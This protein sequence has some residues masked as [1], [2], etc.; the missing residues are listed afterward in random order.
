MNLPSP[1]TAAQAADMLGA[2]LLGDGTI[3]LTGIN[4]IHHVRSGDMS[5]VDHPKYYKPALESSATVILINKEMEAPEGK[6]LLLTD[7][8][9]R[10][11]NRMMAFA[12]PPIPLNTVGQP[13]LGSQVAIGQ[14]V[15]FGEEVIIDDDV[16][17][18]HQVVIGSHVRIGKGSRVQAGVVIGDYTIIGAGCTIGAGTVI[19]TD[20][21]Y[22]K[23]RPEGYDRLNSHGGVQ[24]GDNVDI[25]GNCNIDRG[26]TAD[27]IID[28]GTKIDALVH[29][30]HDSKVGKHCL[31]AG[32]SILAGNVTLEDEVMVWGKVGISQNVV[33]GKGATVMSHARVTQDLKA[34]GTY[35]GLFAE[36]HRQH[37]RSMAALRR[38][39]KK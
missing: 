30:G 31:I 38:L 3:A 33:V 32:N 13:S 26:T 6:A 9:F 5:F 34:G 12:R 29:I 35:A 23:R 21:L 20:A 24:I 15:V 4:E 16:E 19:G 37:L 22:Y 27:T 2:R 25:G 11:F 39:S 36:D 18:G 7:D 8:P 17:I 10:D 14:H 28:D 1:L